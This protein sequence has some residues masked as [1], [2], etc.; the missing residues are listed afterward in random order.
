MKKIYYRNKGGI[1]NQLF[2]YGFVK[3]ISVK[4]NIKFVID[5]SSGF[6]N[7]F[8]KRKPL[9]NCVINDNFEEAGFFIQF[10]FKTYKYIPDFVLK[11]L[12][13]FILN[14]VSIRDQLNFDQSIILTNSTVIVEGYFQSYIYFVDIRNQIAN[15]A[16]SNFGVEER[17]SL[18]Y[19]LIL[20]SNSVSIHVR[21]LQYDNLL[22]VDYYISAINYIESINPEVKFFIFS[23][24]M[25][26]CSENFIGEKYIQVLVENPCEIQELFLMSLCNFHV[27]ANSSFSWWGAWLSKSS[28]KI[29]IA[30]KNTQIGVK[31]L[32]YLN[33]WKIL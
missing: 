20:N 14:E 27:I 9:V 17:Y 4:H 23:D 19:D 31:N 11:F 2:I 29:V 5:N 6:K 30:P 22:D 15:S 33:D 7:D 18:F 8:Y 12:N 13:I 28:N 24:D 32:F 1:G 10:L 3:A 16:F 21:R 26:W 25:T